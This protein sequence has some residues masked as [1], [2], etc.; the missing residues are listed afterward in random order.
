MESGEEHFDWLDYHGTDEDKIDE[1]PRKASA[2]KE[3]FDAVS[4]LFFIAFCVSFCLNVV[5]SHVPH[6]SLN[7]YG[8]DLVSLNRSVMV[9]TG[10]FRLILFVLF[11]CLL[12]LEYL[13]FSFVCK[14]LEVIY[15][16]L[17]AFVWMLFYWL[18]LESGSVYGATCLSLMVTSA[19]YGLL[20]LI[21][22]FFEENLINSTLKAK[23]KRT[24]KTEEILR[25]FKRFAYDI[26]QSSELERRAPAAS[27]MFSIDFST[28]V[29]YCVVYD[30]NSGSAQHSQIRPP[31]I[32]NVKD[33]I[34]LARDVFLKAASEKSEMSADD[35]RSVFD[36]P[37]VFERAKSYIDISRKKNISSRKFRDIVVNFYYSRLSLAKSV[38]SQVLF[39]D[40]IRSLLYTMAFVLLF[41]VY[42]VVFGV[43]IKELFAVVVSSAIVLHFL[44]SATMKDVWKGVM[45]VL[46][47][48]FDIGDDVIIS[49]E[50]MTVYNIGIVSSSFVLGNGG[51][52]KLFNS[53]LCNKPIV[54]VT[55]APENLLIFTFDLPSTISE[56]K[57]NRF[58]KAVSE[59]LKQKRFDF[60][61]SFVLSSQG[62]NCTDVK[63]LKTALVLKCRISNSRSRMFMLR[64]DF[65][66]FLSMQLAELLQ[67]DTAG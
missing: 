46:S 29:S 67:K 66:S 51:V 22:V 4:L 21:M 30:E 18:R 52:I 48:R 44:G 12:I 34:R 6:G 20:S 2:F 26:P 61:D 14:M 35:L 33:A 25:A 1:M 27:D 3:I 23:I 13:E 17:T 62:P 41:I 60:Y 37:N 15:R 45:L 55:N 10:S 38:K 8:A 39:V 19:A 54:N 56:A 57:L 42:L 59:C 24:G 31:E 53:E 9:F 16:Y 49:G 65:S 40:I 64:A 11:T 43:D 36:D 7:V 50:E 58:K 32:W 5:F 47:H 63:T 28:I